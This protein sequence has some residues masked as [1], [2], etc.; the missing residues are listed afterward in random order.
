MKHQRYLIGAIYH[1]VRNRLPF[2]ARGPHILCIFLTLAAV[3]TLV[4]GCSTQPPQSGPGTSQ[5]TES[6]RPFSDEAELKDYAL[7]FWVC[8]P[9][10][11]ASTS[12]YQLRFFY[13]GTCFS[14]NFSYGTDQ[15]LADCLKEVLWHDV[16][17]YKSTTQLLLAEINANGMESLRLDVAYDV[18]NSQI[19]DENGET[20]GIF[21]ED[22][23]L[24]CGQEIFHREERPADL[25]TAFIQ[26]KTS[27]F[28]DIYG[29]LT[30]YEQVKYNPIAHI[31]TKFLL[32][33]TAELDDYYNYD[34]R[35]M[36]ALYFCVCVTPTG[37]GYADRWY[38][39]CERG[40][41]AEL[42]DTLTQGPVSDIV[43]VCRGMFYDSIQHEM[44]GLVDY[45]MG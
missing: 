25:S 41:Y 4:S 45:C 31:G 18:E 14:W 9:P 16:V 39:Y 12:R 40:E 27:L 26:A 42:F 32:T 1:R 29:D 34:Y 3:V 35:D 30:T 13:E 10:D 22:G 7:S 11:S 20:V 37:G 23:T 28:T 6:R 19:V 15:T 43:L 44:A 33:G 2:G 8:E 5:A 38:I 36:E 17:S 21:L 24:K